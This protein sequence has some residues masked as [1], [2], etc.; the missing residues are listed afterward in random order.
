MK[1]KKG[2]PQLEAVFITVDPDRD[3]PEIMKKYLKGMTLTGLFTQQQV[4]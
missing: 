3:T 1:E 2:L 4:Q